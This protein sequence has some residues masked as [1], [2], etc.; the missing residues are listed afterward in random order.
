MGFQNSGSHIICKKQAEVISF[1]D[2]AG[3]GGTFWKGRKIAIECNGI[4]HKVLA[5][6]PPEYR[7]CLARHHH[8]NV[9]ID[10]DTMIWMAD[11]FVKEF[12]ILCMKFKLVFP[13]LWK[14]Y[15]TDKQSEIQKA[16]KMYDCVD[17]IGEHRYKAKQNYDLYKKTKRRDEYLK[18]KDTNIGAGCVIPDCI[19]ANVFMRLTK[20]GLK[21]TIPPAEFDATGARRFKDGWDV[22]VFSRDADIPLY[23]CGNSLA[24][25]RILFP[26]PGHLKVFDVAL[27]REMIRTHFAVDV[28]DDKLRFFL[29]EVVLLF[30]ALFCPHDYHYRLSPA[31][32]H[33]YTNSTGIGLRKFVEIANSVGKILNDAVSGF[34]DKFSASDRASV[35]SNPQQVRD[36]LD[37]LIAVHENQPSHSKM[38]ESTNVTCVQARD[39]V[40]A[41]V[42]QPVSFLPGR[43]IFVGSCFKKFKYEGACSE[44]CMEREQ[45]IYTLRED[46]IEWNANAK[47]PKILL[48]H[49]M[50]HFQFN[51][52][53]FEGAFDGQYCAFTECCDVLLGRA[54]TVDSTQFQFASMPIADDPMRRA[55]LQRGHELVLMKGKSPQSYGC[56]G[57][58]KSDYKDGQFYTPHIILEVNVIDGVIAPPGS[59]G[60]I[61][62]DGILWYSCQCKS[63]AKLCRHIK[64]CLVSLSRVREED[65]ATNHSYAN[66]WRKKFSGPE[67]SEEPTKVR[68]LQTQKEYISDV[69]PPDTAEH[70][71]ID[72]M[73]YNHPGSKCD[74]SEKLESTIND[75]VSTLIKRAMKKGGSGII[76][77]RRSSNK[78][79]IDAMLKK[80]RDSASFITPDYERLRRA[81]EEFCKVLKCK[82]PGAQFHRECDFAPH[83][84]ITE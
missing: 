5:S 48:R 83:D 50:N 36:F 44:S 67:I 52:H 38:V 75:G 76:R 57:K 59:G 34:A 68:E 20:C 22:I 74:S 4:S 72:M 39:A 26:E 13:S 49:T 58:E 65:M 81:N 79:K 33:C 30:C 23:P 45:T 6:I 31:A 71:I 55:V 60:S 78:E 10:T 19:M 84:P 37:H 24:G 43:G 47:P 53:L 29:C 1:S 7:V 17:V 69:L 56:K 64:A 9:S 14:Y 51:M 54:A 66:Y 2:T 16:T 12:C 32:K 3:Y 21:V 27:K 11:T 62:T 25:G 18:D 73:K 63:G 15:P 8:D 28:P 41:F 40:L 61:S 77:K 42:Q 80:A 46:G 82:R 70:E 35:M